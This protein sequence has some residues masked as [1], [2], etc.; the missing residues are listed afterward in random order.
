MT[1]THPGYRQPFLGSLLADAAG[2]YQTRPSNIAASFLFHA[3]ALVLLWLAAASV[4]P[5]GARKGSKS[6]WERSLPIIFSGTGGGSGGSKDLL[7]ASRGALPRFSPNEQF[8]PPSVVLANDNPVLPMAPTLLMAADAV[9]PQSG[10][11]GDPLSG[12]TGPMSNGSGSGGGGGGVCCGGER[13][14]KGRGYGDGQDGLYPAG[15][16]GVTTP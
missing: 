15:R 10:P 3:A 12:V 2:G 4:G 1:A 9:P 6:T 8:A 14:G 13:R 7:P 11:L 5:V 16:N